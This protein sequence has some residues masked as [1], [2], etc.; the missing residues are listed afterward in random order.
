MRKQVLLW[1][2]IVLLTALPLIGCG[3]DKATAA[4]RPGVGQQNTVA[5]V[6]EEG[7][8]TEPPTAEPTA[9]PTNP[10]ETPAPTVQ[11]AEPPVQTTEAPVAMA[12]PQV[13]VDIDLAAM[14][15][16]M[17]YSEIYAMMEHPQ[18]YVGKTMRM[19]G[20][21][22]CS[23]GNLYYFCVIQDATA[24]CAQGIEF[25]LAG[26]PAYPDGYP[27]P[28]TEVTVT[29]VFEDYREG[30]NTYYRLRDAALEG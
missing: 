16:T 12:A 18:D 27:E 14:S 6:L 17:V 10:P 22:A 28:G 30:E 26:N 9:E 24:C 8:A 1:T 25:I 15:S 21:F 3:Q 13:K 11:I 23:E 19:H 4:S 5:K 29:G 20:I 7:M 2:L